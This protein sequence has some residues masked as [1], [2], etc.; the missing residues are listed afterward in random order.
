MS[1]S[2]G[3]GSTGVIT[4]VMTLFEVPCTPASL[5]LSLEYLN[6][7]NRLPTCVHGLTGLTDTTYDMPA[8]LSV[9]LLLLV[10]E[11]LFSGM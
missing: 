9:Q 4:H 8:H 11:L 2:Y 6:H 10:C 3:L 7:S 5:P 1:F